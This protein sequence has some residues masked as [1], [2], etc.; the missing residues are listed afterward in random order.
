MRGCQCGVL[1]QPRERRQRSGTLA[2]CLRWGGEGQ[3]SDSFPQVSACAPTWEKLSPLVVFMSLFTRLAESYG[4]FAVRLGAMLVAGSVV[5]TCVRVF[6]T[7]SQHLFALRGSK[8]HVF[9]ALKI[10]P[11]VVEELP[12][13]WCGGLERI[14]RGTGAGA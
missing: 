1:H 2:E 13:C 3:R 5:T 6:A 12:K 7:C 10:A 14:R 4:W 9:P 11:E 8:R